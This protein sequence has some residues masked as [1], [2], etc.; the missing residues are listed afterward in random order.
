[1]FSVGFQDLAQ[2]FP[3]CSVVREKLFEVFRFEFQELTFR[4]REDGGD[5][6]AVLQDADLA[7]EFPLADAKGFR[8]HFHSHLT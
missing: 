6:F 4:E 5:A 3:D 7:D 1:M 2:S 8:Q